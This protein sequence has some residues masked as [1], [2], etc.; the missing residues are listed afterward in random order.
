MAEDIAATFKHKLGPLP[1]WAWILIGGGVGWYLLNHK[2]AAGTSSGSLLGDTGTLLGAGGGGGGGPI[3]TT[4]APPPAPSAGG[5]DQPPPPIT[6]PTA[7]PPVANPAPYAQLPPW[8]TPAIIPSQTAPGWG[9]IVNPP[10]GV[11]GPLQVAPGGGVYA[12]VGTPWQAFFPGG[13]PT[14][15][16]A[17]AAAAVANPT[18]YNASGVPLQGA[19]PAGPVQVG[20]PVAWNAQGQPTGWYGR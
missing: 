3:D 14:F 10:P 1:T 11:Q 12:P 4:S 2:A 13:I 7:Q 17:P 9:A 15:G 16:A 8:T 19:L 6:L 18:Q 5:G 20:Q